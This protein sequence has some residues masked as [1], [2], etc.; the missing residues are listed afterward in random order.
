MDQPVKKMKTNRFTFLVG[1]CSLLLIT[2]PRIFGS[3]ADSLDAGVA[4]GRAWVGQI[5][6]GLYDESYAAACSAMHEKVTQEKWVLVLQ[7][8]RAKWGPVVNRKEVSHVYKADGV[9]GLPGECM[10]ITNDT[11]FKNL[12][13]ALEV[14]VLKWDNGRWRGAGYNCGPRPSDQA[15]SVEAPQTETSTMTTKHPPQHLEQ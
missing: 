12:N 6:N 3:A 13:D 8:I 1:I 5:D 10:I 15:D 4:T 9:D 14:I 7:T 2:T 11:T